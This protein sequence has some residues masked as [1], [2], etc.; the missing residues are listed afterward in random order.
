MQHYLLT[1]ELVKLL[2]FVPLRPKKA[3]LKLLCA[4]GVSGSNAPDEYQVCF[5]V[6]TF[7]LCLVYY[8]GRY[9]NEKLRCVL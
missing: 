4:Y 3:G 7:A 9:V 1:F 5:F 2:A 8:I 6:T